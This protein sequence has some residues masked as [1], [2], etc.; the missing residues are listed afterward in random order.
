MVDW[1]STSRQTWLATEAADHAWPHFQKWCNTLSGVRSV[2]RRQ[3]CFVIWEDTPNRAR[4]PDGEF[5]NGIGYTYERPNKHFM[6][7][8]VI[9]MKSEPLVALIVG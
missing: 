4:W 3:T 9:F 7:V 2:E 1:L 5:I 6:A 8:P